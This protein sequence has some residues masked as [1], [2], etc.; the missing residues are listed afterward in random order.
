MELTKVDAYLRKVD[1]GFEFAKEFALN[2]FHIRHILL[3]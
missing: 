3:L 2:R 1:V